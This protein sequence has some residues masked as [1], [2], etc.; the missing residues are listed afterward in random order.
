MLLALTPAETLESL[1]LG[2]VEI[3]PRAYRVLTETGRDGGSVND[4]ILSN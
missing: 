3:V 2:C 4:L 1:D